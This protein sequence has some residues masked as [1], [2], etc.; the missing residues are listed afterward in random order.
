MYNVSRVCHT[1]LITPKTTPV[2]LCSRLTEHI[3]TTD[4]FHWSIVEVWEND[5]MGNIYRSLR[6]WTTNEYTINVKRCFRFGFGFTERTLENH[7]S[8]LTCYH[9]MEQEK[10]SALMLRLNDTMF[11]MFKQPRVKYYHL[12]RYFLRLFVNRRSRFVTELLALQNVG[13]RS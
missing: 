4:R 6:D 3:R 13:Y 9:R 7:E 8:V 5:G 10:D 11:E 12:V 2:E 1:V